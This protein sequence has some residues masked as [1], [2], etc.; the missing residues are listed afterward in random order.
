MNSRTAFD[1]AEASLSRE[2]SGLFF[3]GR[4]SLEGEL[5]AFGRATTTRDGTQSTSKGRF[6]WTEATGVPKLADPNR[7]Q[8]PPGRTGWN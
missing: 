4:V 7:G 8:Y 5:T 6:P 3:R 2:I 1:L